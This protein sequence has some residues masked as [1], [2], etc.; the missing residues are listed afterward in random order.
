VQGFHYCKPVTAD[1]IKDLTAI[2]KPRLVLLDPGS[3][4]KRKKT[5]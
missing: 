4:S 5:I 2:K 3:K 1:R